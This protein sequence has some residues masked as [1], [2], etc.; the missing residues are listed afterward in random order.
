MTDLTDQE[1]KFIKAAKRLKDIRVLFDSD[2]L[3]KGYEIANEQDQKRFIDNIRSNTDNIDIAV[4]NAENA[5]AKTEI[6]TGLQA[7]LATAKAKLSG[8]DQTDDY[9]F[10]QLTKN[11]QFKGDE[12]VKY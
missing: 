1:L 8:E 2:G 9:L 5:I 3:V 7:E 10:K 11:V 4:L 6:L 12:E